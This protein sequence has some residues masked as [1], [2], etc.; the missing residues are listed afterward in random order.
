MNIVI[1][2]PVKDETEK[3]ELEKYLLQ[4]AKKFLSRRKDVLELVEVDYDEVP[5]NVKKSFD[6]LFDK[7][8]NVK[9]FSRFKSIEDVF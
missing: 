5:E 9:D 6:E 2:I 8:G 3:K 7:E 4:Q 1:D